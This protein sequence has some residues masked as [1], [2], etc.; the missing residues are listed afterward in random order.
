[1]LERVFR[2][3]YRVLVDGGSL[4]VNIGNTGRNPYVPLTAY[5]TV[6]LQEIGYQHRGE[7]IWDKGSGSLSTAWGSWKSPSNPTLR[8]RHEYILCLCKETYKRSDAQG[9]S[10]APAHWAEL[11]QSIWQFNP[12]HASHIGH[13]APFPVELPTRLIHFY[14]YR[15]DVVLDPFMGSGT[16]A[17]AAKQTGRHY[18]GYEVSAEYVALA[19]QRIQ[20][21]YFETL[22]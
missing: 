4:C 19:E 3:C 14:S 8:D 20:Q 16:T 6:R 21:E 12:A 13:P 22:G 11:T 5:L 7:I 10:T 17:V 18:I 2:E 15:S 1:M 9:E